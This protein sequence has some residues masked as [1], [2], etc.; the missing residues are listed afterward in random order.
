[1]FTIDD[2]VLPT[3]AGLLAAGTAIAAR[4]EARFRARRG[5]PSGLAGLLTV[6][7]ALSTILTCILALGD[8]IQLR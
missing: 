5:Q 3:A 8:A 6:V 1:M 4:A 7:V 2:T